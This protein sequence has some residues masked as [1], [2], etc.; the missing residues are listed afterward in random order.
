MSKGI[1]NRI[2]RRND[3]VWEGHS[4]VLEDLTHTLGG[5]GVGLVL[6]PAV[7]RRSKALG[8]SLILLSTALHL[9]ADVVKPRQTAL[10]QRAHH[11]H[12]AA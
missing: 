2:G 7:R 9:Y 4:R 11:R 8:W 6:Y 12:Q 1:L 10:R 5:A 3:E